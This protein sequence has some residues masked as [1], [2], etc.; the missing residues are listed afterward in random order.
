MDY[1]L[2]IRMELKTTDIMFCGLLHH[3]ITRL[4][5]MIHAILTPQAVG[6]LITI[7]NHS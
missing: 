1:M 4:G 3:L 5:G 2:G 6:S 7:F